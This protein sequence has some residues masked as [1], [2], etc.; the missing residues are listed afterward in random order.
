MIKSIIAISAAIALA[1][2]GASLAQGIRS[3]PL[4]KAE[5]PEGY[6]TV[7]FLIEIPV[8]VSSG[9]HSSSGIETGYV[10]DGEL[11]LIMDGNPLQKLKAGDSFQVP[12][13]TVH[14]AKA[15]GDKALKIFAIFIVANGKP[16]S[17]V[18][19]ELR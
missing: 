16:L 3:T 15:V 14:D 19:K 10:L 18:T 11:D 8:G 5:F 6:E 12:A 1:S 17:E 4:Q 2:T 13:G 9:R 7:S